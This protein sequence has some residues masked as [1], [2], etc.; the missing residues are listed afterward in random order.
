MTMTEDLRRSTGTEPAK[1]ELR[2]AKM[3][4]NGSWVGSMSGA[5]LEATDIGS[6][7]KNKQF[8]EVCG[9]VEDG[10]IR[11]EARLVFGG[12]PP[13]KGRSAK[14]ISRSRPSSPTPRTTGGWHP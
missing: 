4:I 7:I 5:T 6:I 12:L 13:R 2:R 9:Y 1:P 3:L 8:T 14:A 11:K 10:L